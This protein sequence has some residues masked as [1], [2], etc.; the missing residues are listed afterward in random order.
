MRF[1]FYAFSL[2]TVVTCDNDTENRIGVSMNTMTTD[3]EAR[4]R[5][6]AL[7]EKKSSGS[8]TGSTQPHEYN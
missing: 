3:L 1:P 5:F 8:G 2:Y 4:I 7:P 6:P